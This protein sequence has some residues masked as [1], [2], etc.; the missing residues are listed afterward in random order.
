MRAQATGTPDGAPTERI[1]ARNGVVALSGYGLDIRVERAHLQV[2]DGIG[3]ARGVG[4]FHR[5]TDRIRRLVVLGHTGAITLE[6]IRW[7][8]D[9]G[10]SYLQIDR[11]GKVLAAFGPR[12]TDRPS[13][14][15]A[16]AVALGQPTGATIGRHLLGEKLR[17]QAST[18]G[19][20]SA[21]IEV[22]P[23]VAGVVAN[24]AEALEGTSDP[25]G[26]RLIEA[27][28]ALAYWGAWKELPVQ[29]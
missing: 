14:R 11:D 2:R 9:T 1:L 25:P 19:A 6:A 16:Q 15:R 24:L 22:D 27:R 3:A 17:A 4:R 26:L 12:G 21:V 8:S 18:L 23:S 5:A 20:L 10:A 29:F 13:L 7:L 28:G